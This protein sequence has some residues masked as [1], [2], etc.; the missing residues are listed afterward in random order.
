MRKFNKKTIII[1]LIAII[2]IVIGF[3]LLNKNQISSYEFAV[4]KRGNLVHKI[5]VTGR[6]K[7]AENIDLAFEKSGR[8]AKVYVKVGDKVRKGQVLISL[9]NKDLMAQL[10][11]A[12]AGV[13]TA[14]AQ[15]NQYKAALES[16]QAKLDELKR[17]TRPEEIKVKEAELEKAQKDLDNYY[18]AVPDVLNDA[19][20]KADDAINRQIDELFL[21]D[22]TSNPQLTFF[23]ND[24]QI[25]IDVEL[26]R[27]I[28]DQELS[29]FKSEIDNLSFDYLSLDQSLIKAKNHLMIIR[30]FLNLLNEA[31]NH[32]V[33]LNQ[34]TIDTYK[35]YVNLARTNVNNAISQITTQQ[36][37]ILSQKMTRERI[38]NEL[39]LKQAGA[40]PEQIAAQEAQVRQ[41]KAM[42]LSQEAQLEYAKANVENIQAQIEKTILKT[43]IDGIIVKQE[44]KVG[45]IVLPN[46]NIVSVISGAKFEIES[47]IPEADIAQVKIGDLAKVTLDAYGENVI[48]EAKVLKIDPAETIIEG[49][50]TYKTT[51]QFIKEDERLKPGLTANV[52]IITDQKEN[53]ILIPQR[54]IIDKDNEKIVKIIDERGL[55]K[56]VKIETGLSSLNGEIE[57]LSGLKEGDKVIVSFKK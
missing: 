20:I 21:N 38:Q 15:L 7:P 14:T 52:D 5:S 11:Q 26:K 55:I 16:Q 41:A 28:S 8:V 53:V 45:E 57:I 54:A 24:S 56:E 23:V 39:A 18:R 27:F 32:A 42:V 17:G 51:L 9:D 33:G 47:Y 10:T 48:F 43:P 3:K 6:V 34:I 4:A 2:F 36:N 12:L 46:I 22:N 37:Y 35:G 13:K 29:K 30:D 50:A 19:Y 44:A 31:I 25:E 40:T 49:V 1:I